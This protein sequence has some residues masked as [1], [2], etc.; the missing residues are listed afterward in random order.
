MPGSKRQRHLVLEA[1]Y[2][3]TTLDKPTTPTEQI[4]KLLMRCVG[5]ANSQPVQPQKEWSTGFFAAAENS[6]HPD[7]TSTLLFVVGNRH[8]YPFSFVGVLWPPHGGRPKNQS[9]VLIVETT[10]W[11]FLNSVGGPPSYHPVY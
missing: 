7:T 6:K 2:L 1:G 5:A 9:V 10:S 3:L 11:W 4:H 8:G